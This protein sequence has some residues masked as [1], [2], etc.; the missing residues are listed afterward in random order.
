[1]AKLTF[2]AGT[3]SKDVNILIQDSSVSTGAGKTG[4]AYNSGS[5]IAYYHRQ[6]AASATAITLATKTIGTWATGGFVEV[7][8]TH[9]PGLYELGIP[10]AALASGATWV[11]IMLSGASNMAPVTLEIELTSVDNQDAT[12]M[13]L[14][15]LPN[16][17]AAA[18][19][20]LPTVDSNNAVKLQSGTGSNQISLSSGLVTLAGVTHTGATIPTVTTTGTATNVTTVNGLASGVITATSIA[21][22]AITAA[23]I[24][25][26]AIDAATFASGAINAAAI[27][28]D[29]I[30]AAKIAADAIG[31]SE[32]ASDAVAEIQ[33]GLATP[34]NITAGTITT[35]TNLTN[36]PTSGDFTATMK[37]SI[38]T[39]ASSSTPSVTVSDKTG[40]SLSSAGVQAIWDKLTSALTTSGSVGKLIVDNLNAT[41]S[42]VYSRLGAPTNADLATDIAALQAD[43]DDIQTRIPAGLNSGNIT[44]HVVSIANNAI[45]AASI[46]TDAIDADSLAADA[47]TEIGT[48]ISVSAPTVDDIDDKLT[49]MHGS[50][51]WTTATGFATPTNVSDGTATVV[52]SIG[53]QNNLSATQVWAAG[54]R[55]LTSGG[56]PTTTEIW[57][58]ATRTLTSPTPG[59]TTPPA[60]SGTTLAITRAVS[61]DVTM[62]GMT[63]PE[64][65][66]KIY[67]TVKS[68]S[69]QSDNVAQIQIV[70]SNPDDAGDGLLYANGT[71]ASDATQGTLTVD[72]AGGDITITIT[73]DQTE[74]FTAGNYDYDFK[75]ITDESKSTILAR[76]SAT[77][78]TPITLAVA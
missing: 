2:K 24:A 43:T 54:T 58:A 22:D 50:G 17:A 18:T 72:Q 29:A 53:A 52:A 62:T 67:F 42:S 57:T 33:S 65:W 13:G 19:G 73:D 56:A 46:A 31:A 55:T 27:A 41:I 35:V 44:A 5:L 38:T 66:T 14:S 4:L 10:D 3:T 61:F 47:V 20:G 64:N 37:T 40:F 12:R 49:A 34:T 60:I 48:G 36:A 28:T 11:V 7:D 71:T 30:T 1:M 32:L 23:K 75:V 59:S 16:A 77:I 76:G 25:D 26:G 15:A 78:G 9:M 74:D 51:D 45:T 70:I 68:N 21:S 69:S 63:I 8:S 39:A 6:G